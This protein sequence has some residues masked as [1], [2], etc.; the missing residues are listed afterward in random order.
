MAE[1]A[2]HVA[3]AAQDGEADGKF[4]QEGGADVE[5]FGQQGPVFS[6]VVIAQ[7][8]AGD[9]RGN[10]TGDDRQ[11]D[12]GGDERGGVQP[13]QAAACL[14]KAED[15]VPE[16]DGQTDDHAGG[17]AVDDEDAGEAEEMVEL[18]QIL[19]MI[20]PSGADHSEKP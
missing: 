1:R 13:G 20:Y 16:G 10:R 4:Q 17:E 3:G 18:E 7:E 12:A 11:Q 19:E 6:E 8:I 14:F 2:E 5:P 15:D 9:G